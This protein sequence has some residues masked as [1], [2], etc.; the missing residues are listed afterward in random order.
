MWE[1]FPHPFNVK[2]KTGFQKIQHYKKRNWT[3][4]SKGANHEI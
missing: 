3:G 2:R 4:T 1:L